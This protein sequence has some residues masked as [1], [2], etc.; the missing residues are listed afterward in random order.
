MMTPAEA[1][2]LMVDKKNVIILTGAGLSVSG[3]VPTFRGMNGL[4]TREYAYAK[5]PEDICTK[6][7]FK[8]HPE[9]N[10]EWHYDFYE[11]HKKCTSTAGH[12]AIV[13]FQEFCH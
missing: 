2:K 5:N 8:E 12:Q 4:W 11:T 3:G 7:F 9:A 6:K 13:E 1:A 10:W